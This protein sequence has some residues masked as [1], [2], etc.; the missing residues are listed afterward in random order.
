[1]ERQKFLRTCLSSLEKLT[2]KPVEVVLVD[3]N[4]SD[5]SV[6]F[7]KKNFPWVKLIANHKNDGFAKGNNIGVSYSTGKYVCFLNNDTKS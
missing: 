1:M 6:G 2:Y 3:N 4:S 5:D 7:V